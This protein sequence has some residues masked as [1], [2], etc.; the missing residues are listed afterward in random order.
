MKQLITYN[1]ARSN[2]DHRLI[3]AAFV[4]APERNGDLNNELISVNGLLDQHELFGLN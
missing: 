2:S 4:V 1:A 3:A